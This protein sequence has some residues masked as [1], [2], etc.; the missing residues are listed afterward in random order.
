MTAAA[1]AL[2]LALAAAPD[3]GAKARPSRARAT[4]AADAGAARGAADGGLALLARPVRVTA[5]KLDVFGKEKRAVYSGAARAERDSTVL[6]CDELSVFYAEDQ[7]VTRILARGNVRAV[8]EHREATGDEATYDNTTGVLVATGNPRAVSAGRRVTGTKVIFTTGIDRIEIENPRS[9]VDDAGKHAKGQALEIDAERLVL[10]QQR[11]QATWTGKVR[12]KKATALLRAPVLVAHYD[13]RGEVTRVEA[14]GG[15]E[16]TDGD[17]WARGQ[18][19][20][21]D[22]AAGV[23]VVTGNPQARQGNNRMKGSRVTFKAGS[24]RLVVDDATTVIEAD[25]REKQR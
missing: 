3:G 4:P 2:A 22:N 23:L 12:A 5:A 19:A 15:V 11:S 20:T 7:T 6:T 16:V 17:K 8:D 18:R 25:P 14:R 24:E 1:L 10:D 21:F 9:V 13:E